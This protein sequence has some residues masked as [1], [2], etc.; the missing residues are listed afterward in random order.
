MAAPNVPVNALPTSTMPLALDPQGSAG[1]FNIDANGNLRVVLGGN[2]QTGQS[3]CANSQSVVLATDHPMVS[4]G[5]SSVSSS[6]SLALDGTDAT[7][8]APQ[9]G[10]SGIRGWL[11]SIYATLTGVVSGSTVQI[12]APAAIPVVGS[13]SG[14][15][16][17]SAPV[18]VA[19]FPAIQTV[20]VS[21]AVSVSNF[22]SVQSIS[23]AVSLTGLANPLPVFVDGADAPTVTLVTGATGVRGWLSMIYGVLSGRVPVGATILRVNAGPITGTSTTQIFPPAGSGV[24]NYLTSIQ[25]FNTANLIGSRIDI[26][27]GSTTIWTGYVGSLSQMSPIWFDPPLIGSANTALNVQAATALTNT[28]VNAQGYKQ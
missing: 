17:L 25:I 13:I 8:V 9:S 24:K 27:D 10:A 5:I 6:V 16:T 7:A 15:V 3:A 18:S 21:S 23:G 26:L 1:T 14:A 2:N 19:N 4:I 22:P 11:S 12:S 20:S 28:F